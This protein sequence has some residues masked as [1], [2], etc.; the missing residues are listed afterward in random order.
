MT[1]TITELYD[2]YGAI[3]YRNSLSHAKSKEDYSLIMQENL[4]GL[5]VNSYSISDISDNYKSITDTLSVEITD[6]AELMG[7]KI[8]FYPLLF[9]RTEKN[10]YTLDVRKYPVDYNYL[11]LEM[12][13]F[14]YTIP[15]GYEV[16]SLPQS[17]ILKLPDNSISISYAIQQNGNKITLAYKRN[18]K[19]ILF[20]PQ[21]YNDLKEMYNQIVKKH[22]EMV[23]LKKIV[24]K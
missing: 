9:E 20:L 15:A 8:L 19:K 4:K 3:E 17:I 5:T 21:E 6:H 23:V 22:G 10:R 18:I 13:I 24:D 16:E 11:I 12:Y 1:G 7:D 14:E 2:G